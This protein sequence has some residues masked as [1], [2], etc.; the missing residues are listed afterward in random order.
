MKDKLKHMLILFLIIALILF[1]LSGWYS[2][3]NIDHLAYV[4]ALGFDISENNNLKLSFQISVPGSSEESSGSSQSDSSIV[5]T[6]EGASF[7]SC[8]NL[9]NSYLSKQS[10]LS[11]CKM[12]VFSEEFA[13]NGVSDTLYTLINNV[14]VRP[15]CSVLVSRCNAEYF[16]KNS[17]PTL[18]KLSARYYE[19]APTSSEYTGYT[20]SITLNDFF[21]GYSDTFQNC[22]AILGGIN[23]KD[24]QSTNSN[25]SAE[26]KDSTNKANESLIQGDNNIENMGLAV[27]N[28]DTLV[29]ELNGLETI[30]HQIISGSLNSCII[31]IQS[32]FDSD[33]TISLKISLKNNTKN[34]VTLVN[35]SAYI[36]SNIKLEARILTMEENLDYLNSDEIEKLEDSLNSYLTTKIYEYLYKVSK[37]FKSDI[38]GFGKYA[39]Q[40]F[41]TYDEW[42]NFNWLDN[43]ENSFFN[44]AV[45]TTIKSGYIL[46]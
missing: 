16:L 34:N 27:F 42:E 22:Y 25:K 6:V 26:E 20:Q 29:G 41:K 11:H 37:E 35:N 43:F 4:V 9:L 36:T 18:E 8:I 44:I 1:T 32:P 23:T 5:V 19:I 31:S 28:G 17:K 46:Q 14:E 38:D 33:K 3:Q 45:N 2:E 30:C 10:N 7:N 40:N 15:D 13:K 21:S 24:S 12:I 39:V